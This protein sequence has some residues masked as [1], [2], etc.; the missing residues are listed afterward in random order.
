MLTLGLPLAGSHVAQVAIGAVDTLMVGWY[1]VTELA[2]LTIAG[3]VWFVFFLTISGFGWAAT[4]MVAEASEI[5]DEQRIRRVTRMAFW[6]VTGFGVL[7]LI[8]LWYSEAL[9]LVLGQEPEVARLAQD[10][11][12]ITGFALLPA[13][14]IMVLK[15][16]LSALEHT[17]IAFWVTAGAI[18]PNAGLNYLLIFGHFGAP[19]MGVQGAATATLTV[20]VASLAVVIWYA[21]RHFPQHT[22][23]A[24][25]WRS[26]WPVFGQVFRLGW[27]IAVT[28]VS[29]VGLFTGAA[30][31][32]GLIGTVELAA[33][34]IAIQ[35]ASLTFVMHL[36][37]SQA[38]TVRAG[39][40]YGRQSVTDLHRSGR[41]SV[42]LSV[43]M[44]LA[45]M[46]V[47]L[48]LP[49]PLIS[50]FLDRDE[51]A[52]DAIVSIGVTL[53]AMA[54]LFQL[55]DGAQ[56]TALGLLRGVQDTQVPMF[57]AAFSYWVIGMPVAYGLGIWMGWGGVGVWSGLVLGLGVAGAA[58]MYRFW[59]DVGQRVPGPANPEAR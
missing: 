31:L 51:P 24:R 22:L 10:Y 59:W 49:E 12:R 13:L 28:S 17:G 37:I 42:A 9:M 18:L 57:I 1:G 40:A 25:I 33:H 47:F 44:A 14:W 55:M 21:L 34:G 3:S 41:V 5:G 52:R 50:A 58:L 48:S 36:G 7:A 27:P 16:Y 30:I 54:A 20:Q 43:T 35:I 8:P 2:A 29:E 39:R 15:S 26:D 45:T 4:P 6:L 32:M 23:F 56:V 53:L 19:E 11:L 38:A 46:V